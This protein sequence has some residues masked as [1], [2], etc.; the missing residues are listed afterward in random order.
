MVVGKTWVQGDIQQAAHPDSLYQAVNFTGPFDNR[1]RGRVPEDGWI[2]FVDTV[3]V[4][5]TE[6]IGVY[7]IC[8]D[9]H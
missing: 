5:T 9:K 2:M 6:P 7:A 4:G 1:D 8:R 3:E